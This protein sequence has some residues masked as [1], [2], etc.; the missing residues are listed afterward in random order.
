MLTISISPTK[1]IT[2]VSVANI[3][4]W[5]ALH[6]D[7]AGLTIDPIVQ[8]KPGCIRPGNSCNTAA[9][10]NSQAWKW[11]PTL[12]GA[13]N[14]NPHANNADKTKSNNGHKTN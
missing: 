14:T 3:N 6:I 4:G 8:Q 2:S 5:G 1:T 9:A 10:V 13:V 7:L 12:P 11:Q